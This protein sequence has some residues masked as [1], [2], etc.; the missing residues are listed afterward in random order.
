MIQRR[1]NRFFK[2]FLYFFI[3][4]LA[5]VF[6]IN[7]LKNQLIKLNEISIENEYLNDAM[8]ICMQLDAIKPNENYKETCIKIKN[9]IDFNKD[10]LNSLNLAFFYLDYIKND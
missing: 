2:R 9:K 10:E 7:S 6:F 8:A 4:F 1:S 3:T 5:I